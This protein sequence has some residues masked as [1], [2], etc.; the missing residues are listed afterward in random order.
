MDIGR[1]LP[2]V[3]EARGTLVRFALQRV[4]FHL[5]AVHGL[6]RGRCMVDWGRIVLLEELVLSSLHYTFSVV[7]FRVETR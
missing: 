7:T 3:K 1:C 5:V 4:F 2:G 6:R